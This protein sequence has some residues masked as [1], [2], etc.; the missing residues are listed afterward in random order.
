MF[1]RSMI[2]LHRYNEARRA[3]EKH[4][5]AVLE[6][7]SA[8]QHDLPGI[9]ISQTEVRRALAQLQPKAS[10]FAY[11]ISKLPNAPFPLS[12]LPTAVCQQWGLPATAKMAHCFTFGIGR[13]PKYQRVNSKP[14]KTTALRKD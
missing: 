7:V 1:H 9:P 14:A 12:Q 4:S 3:G 10:P 5:A 13:H 6:A 2:A 11:L 8:V